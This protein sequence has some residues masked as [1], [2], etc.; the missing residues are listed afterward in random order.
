MSAEHKRNGPPSEGALASSVFVG[1][2]KP[3]FCRACRRYHDSMGVESRVRRV[4]LDLSCMKRPFD[5]QTQGRIRLET[6]AVI[7]LVA[8][9]RASTIEIVASPVLLAENSLNPDPIRLARVREILANLH[10]PQVE[11][12]SA[13]A[14]GR[15]LTRL[16]FAALDAQH[17]A[18]AEAF[19]AVLL[20]TDDRLLALG[21]RHR[22]VLSV[23]L[24]N[25]VPYLQEVLS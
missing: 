1:L 22:R 15:S 6:E 20:S 3:L 24:R 13:F 18:W 21:R 4:Y 8:L 19:G 16:G 7:Q 2:E 23:E 11:Q 12:V 14:R 9:G 5:D 10:W 25:P 17:V